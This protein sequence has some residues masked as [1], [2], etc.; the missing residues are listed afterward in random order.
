MGSGA[1]SQ[2]LSW[3]GVTA[4]H[5][6]TLKVIKAV[7]IIWGVMWLACWLVEYPHKA[8][9]DSISIGGGGQEINGNRIPS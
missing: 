8:Q 4:M 7:L 9:P 1:G 5:E 3:R 6:N 2:H